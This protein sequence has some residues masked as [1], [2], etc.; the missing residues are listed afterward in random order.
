MAHK[1][2]M[3]LSRPLARALS[4]PAR[5]GDHGKLICTDNWDLETEASRRH[6]SPT[7]R[8]VSMSVSHTQ[9]PRGELL[10]T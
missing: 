1:T 2:R 9:H 3:G 6:F 4:H 10:P 7:R 8:V 5:H